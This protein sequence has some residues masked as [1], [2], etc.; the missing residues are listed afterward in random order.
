MNLFSKHFFMIALLLCISVNS[1]AGKL[2]KWVDKNG[3]VSYQDQPPPK[4]AKILSEKS[5]KTSLDSSD[6]NPNE[7]LPQVLIYTVANCA[8]CEYFVNILKRENVPHIEL[9]LQSD[10]EAQ[11]RIL[12]QAD[13]LS[14]PTLFIGEQL[15]QTNDG[16]KLKDV[17]AKAGYAVTQ[18]APKPVQNAPGDAIAEENTGTDDS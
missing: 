2:Y 14:A 12:A 15:L 18:E 6:G 4:D 10:R 3:V 17:L 8:I 16:G 11:S 9:P 7:D 5:V 13:S 1:Y